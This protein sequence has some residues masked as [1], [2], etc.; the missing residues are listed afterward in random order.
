MP[1]HNNH[2]VP[3][4]LGGTQQVPII[5]MRVIPSGVVRVQ[6]GGCDIP[7]RTMRLEVINP[8][9]GTMWAV[10]ITDTHART[11]RD[12]LTLLLD[13]DNTEARRV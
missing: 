2:G 10:P 5:E 11:L 9:T 1:G 4:I 13:R 3:P 12:Q 7:G 6:L 8:L